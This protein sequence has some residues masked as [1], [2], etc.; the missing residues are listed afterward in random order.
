MDFDLAAKTARLSV[1]ELAD[2]AIGPRDGGD[3]PTGIWRAQLG[4]HW[5]REMQAQ[6]TS[7]HPDAHFEVAI[8]GE[9]FHRGWRLQLS[10]RIDQLLHERGITVLREIKTV[11]RAVPIPDAELR[12][13]YPHYFAQLA[14]YLTLRRIHAPST[15]DAE[16]LR[17]ELVFVETASGLSQTL[18]LTREDE[19]LLDHRLDRVAQF[20][21]LNLRALERRRHL[22]FSPPFATLR[23]GQ[24]DTRALLEAAFAR[25]SIVA[26]EAPTGF[27]KTGVMLE[28]ALH[29]LRDTRVD[30]ILYLTSKATGQLQVVDTLQRMTAPAPDATEPAGAEALGSRTALAIWHVRN[31]AEHCVNHTFHCVRDECR[32]LQ[33]LEPRWPQSGLDRFHLFEDHPRDLPTLRAAGTEVGICPYE[34]T[35]TALAF[36][37]VW[38]GDY[39][40]VFAPRNRGLF[41]N[42]PGWNPAR[43]L[44]IIDEAHNLPARVADAHS[45][46]LT[47]AAC[48]AVLAELDHLRA[49]GPLLRAW[50]SLTL[51]VSG[52]RACEALDLPTEDD[53]AEI[54]ARVAD[55][56]LHVPL[57]TAALGP[58]LAD[59]LWRCADLVEWLQSP[60]LTRLL[61]APRDGEIAFTCLDAAPVIGGILRG[62]RQVMLASATFG[63]AEAFTASLGLASGEL[64]TVQAL[65]PWR[66]HAY[67]VAMDARV[68]TR[69][70]HRQR[71]HPLT[72]ATIARLH[73]AA[74]Q[75]VVVFFPSY[76]Y[77]EAIERQ[78]DADGHALRV[79]LQPRLPDLAAQAAWV[80]QNL[81]FADVLFLV[82]GSS[83][84]EG[85]DLLGGRVS[86]AMVVGPALPEVNARQRTRLTELE[87]TG[88]SREE[89]FDRV[90]RI[91][92]LQKVNQGL[93]RLVR[94]PG[95]HTRVLL[96]CRRFLD[97]PFARLLAR[98]YQFGVHL[99]DDAAF[100]AWLASPPPTA[101]M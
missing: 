79:A 67:D 32:F 44:L 58:D 93:G 6:T 33:D 86:H 26:F 96:H 25:Q 66:E 19:A 2:F 65:T 72:A 1:G 90:Y 24:E 76:A 35:R 47:A 49:P 52:Q 100:E 5:H 3:G 73:E 92:G 37:D 99:N 13:D 63:P 85:I 59:T 94:A 51:L 64:G 36:Q 62:F 10:G 39:N 23:A 30:R 14:I 29:A 82:L 71:H 88:A 87:R 97:T 84:A 43:T 53:L 60:Q 17:G 40:Y 48:R 91:P 98:D 57:D 12:A 45:H 89:A 16:R 15:G 101:P 83:F 8:D 27:G 50:E 55:Q 81:A 42:Q 70:Q 56:L 75:A 78:L 7:E 68:D 41:E 18:V 21:D 77:A 9:I 31:K 95:Q 61:W 54:L 34:I 46:D 4:S 38:I 22:R 28:S 74:T 11:T 69:F 20:L 80:E